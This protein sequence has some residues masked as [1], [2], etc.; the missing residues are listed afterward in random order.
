MNAEGQWNCRDYVY[1]AVDK[2]PGITLTQLHAGV[3]DYSYNTVAAAAYFH[4]SEGLMTARWENGKRKWYMLSHTPRESYRP[5][6]LTQPRNRRLSLENLGDQARAAIAA[7]TEWD[8]VETRVDDDYIYFIQV[9]GTRSRTQRI[10]I[11]NEL[12]R[13][14]KNQIN[15]NLRVAE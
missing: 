14:L 2:N 10:R 11:D 5:C 13:S 8:T 3:P 1:N 4:S 15:A 6:A 7:R 9:K 12:K